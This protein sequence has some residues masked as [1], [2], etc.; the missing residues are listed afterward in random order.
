MGDKT[1][2]GYLGLVG[3]WVRDE[4]VQKAPSFV[5]GIEKARRMA[6][7]GT[8]PGASKALAS[9]GAS[10]LAGFMGSASTPMAGAVLE[11]GK[12]VSKVMSPPDPDEERKR[13]DD[14]VKKS[15]LYQAGNLLVN[16][17]EAMS[18]YGTLGQREQRRSVDEENRRAEMIFSGFNKAAEERRA[19]EEREMM[20]REKEPDPREAAMF[21][22]R[23]LRM[24]LGQ[25]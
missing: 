21:L 11:I 10:R 13:A 1:G 12:G 16:T 19:K 18:Q 6:Q 15:L 25:I 8:V 22:I 3:E 7:V 9:I 14:L 23:D 5:V 20:I 17:S 2:G 4:A 24:K